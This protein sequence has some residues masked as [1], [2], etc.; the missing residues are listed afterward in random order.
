MIVPAP[1]SLALLLLAQPCL[2]QPP[3]M[4]A[5]EGRVPAG[6]VLKVGAL[7]LRPG[8]QLRGKNL[9][10]EVIAGAKLAG[11][12]LFEADLRADCRAAD[13]SGANLGSADFRGAPVDG[14]RFWRAAIRGAKGLA[15]DKAAPLP[16][17]SAEPGEPVGCVK[18]LV[19]TVDTDGWPQPRIL[20][21]GFT[22]GILV[23][24]PG[25]PA[26]GVI[27]PA[28]VWGQM[29][30]G[31]V[32]PL[33]MAKAAD[34][35]CWV[36]HQGGGLTH[37]TAYSLADQGEGKTSH[38]SLTFGAPEELTCAAVARDGRVAVGCAGAGALAQPGR[39][40]QGGARFPD[41]TLESFKLGFTPERIGFADSLLKPGVQ[42][43]FV[44]DAGQIL[45][46]PETASPAV[47]RAEATPFRGV[48]PGAPGQLWALEPA[49]DT[50]VAFQVDD[51]KQP[52]RRIRPF[53]NRPGPLG[54]HAITLGP[55]GRMWFTMTTAQAIGRVNAD[56]SCSWFPLPGL[57]PLE[58]CAAEDG[59]LYFT[60][61]DRP[62]IGSIRALPVPG[63]AGAAAGFAVP[64]YH[65]RPERR[66]RPRAERLERL[67]R[68]MARDKGRPPEADDE[69]DLRPRA[70]QSPAAEPKA[71]PAASRPAA[72]AAAPAA[73][74][75]EAAT[76]LLDQL[77]VFLTP[78]GIGHIL[79]FHTGFKHPGHS[80]FA[81]RTEDP[82]AFRQLLAQ[83][84]RDAGVI[85]RVRSNTRGRFHTYCRA[86]APVG[87][88]WSW[89]DEDW[90][91]T[92]RF[93]VVTEPSWEGD[94]HDVITAY[95][96]PEDW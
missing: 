88:C 2:A 45:V 33:Q 53:P 12:D 74:T 16:F 61:Q 35:R 86:A 19:V 24:E 52:A 38:P 18:E 94:A 23:A 40:G 3:K 14:A 43:L 8:A 15:L 83:G 95:P 42:I 70:P 90:V 91:A 13:F 50:L 67:T 9:R 47:F 26:L 78:R 76:D 75:D 84:L 11:A 4:D 69:P 51:P 25:N 36:F 21:P 37:A 46:G 68:A 66:S 31:D 73:M 32:R 5:E 22:R 58:L 93:T 44:A 59:R 28:G 56:G 80:Q 87:F 85:G 71:A 30:L 72:A 92:T 49:T 60:V 65:P 82:K 17:F 1:A 77:D 55:D 57:A 29:R 41:A 34:D 63:P 10:G 7:E 81:S 64:V 27:H 79:K 48:A 89:R 39:V 20:I 6:S 62:T 96:V 54:L